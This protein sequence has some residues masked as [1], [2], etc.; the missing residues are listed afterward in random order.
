MSL[1]S[2]WAGQGSNLQP[3]RLQFRDALSIELPARV[4]QSEGSTL[5]GIVALTSKKFRALILKRIRL[6]GLPGQSR[7]LPLEPTRSQP[8]AMASLPGGVPAAPPHLRLAMLPPV[9]RAG[10]TD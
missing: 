3:S 10:I 2:E 5:R 7:C 1:H 9:L 6:P 4:P 8:S